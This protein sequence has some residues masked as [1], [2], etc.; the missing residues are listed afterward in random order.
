MDIPVLL[1]VAIPTFILAA[2]GVGLTYHE[3][4]EDLKKIDE[5]R[6]K[7]AKKAKAKAKD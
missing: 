7:K 2:V 1:E 5:E 4:H 3:F 6:K